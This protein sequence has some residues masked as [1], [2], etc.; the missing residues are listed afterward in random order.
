MPCNRMT[1]SLLVLCLAGSAAMAADSLAP[2]GE[3]IVLKRCEVEYV[4]SSQVGVASM[5]SAS[6]ILQDCFVRQGDRVQ[7]GQVLGRIRDQELRVELELRTLEAENDIEVRLS[8]AKYAQMLSKLKR[9]EELAHR[10]GRNYI[11]EEELNL[12]RIEARAS[13]LDV[14]NAKYRRR[15]AQLQ[16]RHTEAQVHA[17]E[18][19]SPHDGTVVEIL[20][21]KG[22]AIS[23]NEPVFRVVDVAHLQITGHINLDDYWRVKKGQRVLVFPEAEGMDLPIEREEFEGRVTFVDRRIDPTTRTCKILTEV[24]NRDQLLA[25]GLEARMEIF[26][27]ESGTEPTS[28]AAID[29]PSL[30]TSRPSAECSGFEELALPPDK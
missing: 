7:A 18:F 11:S 12:H 28:S 30:P 23:I 5:G 4:R 2:R 19:I 13:V 29:R 17:R 26:I 27:T 1:G 8:E 15:L 16:K 14:E 9:S 24:D 6:T 25:S 22:E 3:V 20:K 10:G 21:N